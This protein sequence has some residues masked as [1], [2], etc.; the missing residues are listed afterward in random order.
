MELAALHSYHARL[1]SL[2]ALYQALGGGWDPAQLKLPDDAPAE[3]KGDAP[4]VVPA[5]AK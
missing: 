1:D 3:K 5:T 4:T 2:V